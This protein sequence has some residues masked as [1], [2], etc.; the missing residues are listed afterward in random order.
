MTGRP[1]PVHP[2]YAGNEGMLAHGKLVLPIRGIILVCLSFFQ[3]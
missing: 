3:P 2:G 1:Y